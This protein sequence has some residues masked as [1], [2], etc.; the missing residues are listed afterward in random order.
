[1]GR[2]FKTMNDLHKP[3]MDRIGFQ[4]LITEQL[5][6]WDTYQ[7]AAG[8]WT[9]RSAGADNSVVRGTG[10]AVFHLKTRD[11]SARERPPRIPAVKEDI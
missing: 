10:E 5:A 2:T 8:V 3:G 9:Q 4:D 7:T 11:E 6:W 1:M